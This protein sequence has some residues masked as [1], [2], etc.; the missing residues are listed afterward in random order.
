MQVDT[1]GG[2][3]MRMGHV[4]SVRETGE[5]RRWRAMQMEH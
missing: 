2:R 5:G 4:D 1:D 3:D